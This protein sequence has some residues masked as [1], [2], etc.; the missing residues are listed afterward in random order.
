ME[1]E[2][3][4]VYRFEK[5]TGEIIVEVIK[6]YET[7]YGVKVL[8]NTFKPHAVGEDIVDLYRNSHL[9]T[10]YKLTRLN[11]IPNKKRRTAVEMEI[12]NLIEHVQR[13]F[14]LNQLYEAINE[15][16]DNNNVELFVSL[17]KEY[18]KLKKRVTA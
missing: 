14:K 18:A 13:N 17:T 8:G 9:F 1:L 4:G 15:A 2:V 10:L 16:L 6:K 7:Y 3:G 11:S 12:D 5:E